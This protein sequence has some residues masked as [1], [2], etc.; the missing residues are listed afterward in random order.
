MVTD[1]WLSLESLGPFT[2]SS[3]EREEKNH[4]PIPQLGGKK[5][6][7]DQGISNKR[8]KGRL[9]ESEFGLIARKFCGKK[10]YDLPP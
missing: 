3:C 7:K 1:V 4:W 8:Q 5:G 10:N 2:L 9:W 6:S